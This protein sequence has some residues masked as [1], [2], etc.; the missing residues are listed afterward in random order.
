MK[1]KTHVSLLALVLLLST[2]NPQ[3]STC[4]AAPLASGLYNEFRT[5]TLNL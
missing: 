2:L 4:L 5:S 1:T 3:L